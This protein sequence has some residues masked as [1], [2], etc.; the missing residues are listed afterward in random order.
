MAFQGIV[1]RVAAVIFLIF[2]IIIGYAMY[3]SKYDDMYPDVI[4][5]CPDYWE[6]RD[7]A[8]V[9]TCF[10]TNSLGKDSCSKVMNFNTPDWLGQNS[11]C[12]KNQWASSCDLTW[13]GVSNN[14]KA[15]PV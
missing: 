13:D 5:Q 9:P 7:K 15:C 3:N 4:S 12:R 14:R 1:V 10:N 6:V 2:F 11:L 8:G